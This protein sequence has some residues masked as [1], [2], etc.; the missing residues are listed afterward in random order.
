MNYSKLVSF[1]IRNGHD[2]DKL[3]EVQNELEKP[4]AISFF[5]QHS[6]EVTPEM[7]M[8]APSLLASHTLK[9][10]FVKGDPNRV[11]YLSKEELDDEVVSYLDSISYAPTRKI[12]E[13]NPVLFQIPSLVE[14]SESEYVDV[15]VLDPNHVFSYI[16]MFLLEENN[17]LFRESDFIRNPNLRNY[18]KIM[19]CAIRQNPS[20][21]RYIGADIMLSPSVLKHALSEYPVTKEVLEENPAMVQNDYLMSYLIFRN[22][23]FKLYHLTKSEQRMYIATFL[24]EKKYDALLSLPFM[25]PPFQKRFQSASMKELLPY[26]DVDL[27]FNDV[28]TQMKYQQLLNQLFSM[29]AEYDYQQN[30]LHFL[31][32]DVASMNLA[33]QN[34]FLRHEEENL[35]SDLD[36]FINQGQEVVTREQ[37]T[38]L[39]Q[40]VK[41][42]QQSSG[43]YRTKEISNIYSFLLNLHRDVYLSKSVS[44]MKKKVIKDL[45]LSSKAENKVKLGKSIRRI[46]TDFQHQKWDD[47]GGYEHL[48]EELQSKREH[49]LKMHHVRSTLFD[50]TEEEFSQLENLCLQGKLSRETVADTLHSYDVKLDLEVFRFYNRFYA[51]LAKEDKRTSKFSVEMSDKEKFP[52]HYLN[53][54]FANEEHI[55]TVLQTLFSKIKEEDIPNILNT[56]QR[57]P[58][59]ASLLPLVDLVPSFSTDTYLS[60]LTDYPEIYQRLTSDFSA[61]YLYDNNPLLYLIGHMKQVISM[62]NGLKEEEKELYPLILGDRVVSSLPSELLSDYTKVYIE[63]MLREKSSIPQISGSV[64]PYSYSTTTTEPD[65]LLIGSKFSRSCIDLTNVSG[66]PTYRGCLTK[67]NMDVLIVRDK[68][69][70][71]IVARSILFRTKN[72]VMFAPFYDTKG[73]VFEPF[74]QDDVLQEIGDKMMSQAKQKDDSI[75]AILYNCGL[76]PTSD[77]HSPM[78]EDNR[79]FTDFLHADL[80]PYAFVLKTSDK[81]VGGLESSQVDTSSFEKPIYDR[82]RQPVKTKEDITENDLKRIQVLDEIIKQGKLDVRS[83]PILLDDFESLYCGEDWYAGKRKDGQVDC[84]ILPT[85]DVR[86]PM[87]LAQTNLPLNINTFGGQTR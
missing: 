86:V 67:P 85:M 34:A 1:C 68:F 22:H 2:V 62:A 9:M 12:Y 39:V 13:K 38:S 4:G 72:T 8:V 71:E 42:Y 45:E 82:L 51:D 57:F 47:Y 27:S 24:K 21:I 26:F 10:E 25:R 58:E 15:M 54:Q 73:H 17:Y 56:Y 31:Y 46:Q 32:P 20:F 5:E 80:G 64:G 30:K 77:L 69:T 53:Y 44:Q 87:E 23:N 28:D 55:S 35:I 19:E 75:D 50:F 49:V 11:I 6:F 84:V 52:Y 70:H 60:I 76:F 74:L 65:N 83:K 29:Q 63:S 43:T 7:V 66:A 3:K 59:I 79:L 81:Y 48:L 40:S 41:D 36:T 33:F 14:R 61:K 18:K 37:L 78:I 16:D